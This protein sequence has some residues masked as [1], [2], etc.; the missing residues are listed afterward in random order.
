MINLTSNYGIM[1]V[2]VGIKRKDSFV[3]KVTIREAI[4]W[5]YELK[6]ISIDFV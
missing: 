1:I 4:D 2:N 6:P 3:L 5:I